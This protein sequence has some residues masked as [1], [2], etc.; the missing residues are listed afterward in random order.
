MFQKF[1]ADADTVILY[2][3]TQMGIASGDLRQTKNGQLDVATLRRIFYRVGQQIQQNLTKSQSVTQNVRSI[4][5]ADLEIHGLLFCPNRGLYHSVQFLQQFVQV[6][7]RDI[8]RFL[9]AFDFRHIQY[10]IDKL[11]QMLTR[12]GNLPGVLPYFVRL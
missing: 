10:I 9:A 2:L 5:I 1:R 4:H 3:E 7:L 8:Q 12:C 6:K 11:Q